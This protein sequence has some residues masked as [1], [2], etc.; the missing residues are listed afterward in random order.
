M[1]Q[2]MPEQA[3]QTIQSAVDSELATERFAVNAVELTPPVTPRESRSPSVSIIP[4]PPET[5][6]QVGSSR[7]API[8]IESPM[9]ERIQ[10]P[11]LAHAR[12]IK[13]VYSIFNRPIRPAASTSKQVAGISAQYP[14]KETQPTDGLASF[15]GIVPR[16]SLRDKG[17]AR[18][19]VDAE[20]FPQDGMVSL[21]PTADELF[22][23]QTDQLILARPITTIDDY[24]ATLP[25]SHQA[26]P[27]IS[28]L[29][30]TVD[31]FTMSEP[32]DTIQLSSQEQWTDKWRP[33]QAD[34]VLGNEQN[35][36]YLRDWLEALRL[37][38]ESMR[39][40]VLAPTK[41][42]KAKKRKAGKHKKPDIVRHVKKRRRDGREDDFLAPDDLTEEEDD[43][44]NLQSSD[45]DDFG[46]IQEQ[47]A[48]LNRSAYSTDVSRGSSPS[49]STNTED[50]TAILYKPTRF[51]KQ[52]SNTILIAGPSG[53]GKT[54]AVYACAA[55]LGWEVFEVYP[56][57]GERSGAEL[58]KFIGDVGK[59]HTVKVHQSPKKTT[60]KAAFFRQVAEKPAKRKAAARRVMDS[61]DDEID[62]LKSDVEADVDAEMLPAIDEAAEP[63]PTAP[64]ELTV[65]QSVILIEEADVLYQT[66][67]NFWSALVSIISVCRRPVI[68]TCNGPS[69]LLPSMSN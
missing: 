60:A 48:R 65:N 34:Q 66:D 67:T 53:T 16:F 4:G 42:G 14:T 5:Q 41:N 20:I 46:F 39:P 36:L 26:I 8:V 43:Y 50:H 38:D 9:C 45:W 13:P 30:Q 37:Q 54:A 58:N 28:R 44:S 15:P 29:L 21:A 7:D 1:A 10:S 18:E 19:V 57:I 69:L 17:K 12:P 47:N 27:A 25:Q 35:A 56:G 32:E 68:L 22:D 6:F 40:T 33:R 64:M 62:L 51:G 3:S 55:E 59:N 63:E 24:L 52:I 61:S 23:I 2:T 11:P 31:E 49:L